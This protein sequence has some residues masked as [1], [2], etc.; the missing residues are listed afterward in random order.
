MIVA[1]GKGIYVTDT[2]GREYIDAGAGLA[3][4]NVGYGREEI[5]RAIYD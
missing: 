1:R 4:V 5:A 3:C 2:S